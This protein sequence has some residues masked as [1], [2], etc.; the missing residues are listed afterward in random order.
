MLSRFS[1]L[2]SLLTQ[3]QNYWRI[4]PFQLSSKD[5]LPW[6]DSNN[7]LVEWLEKLSPEQVVAYK[8]DTKSLIHAISLFLPFISELEELIKLPEEKINELQLERGLDTG[9]PGRKL[10]QIVSMGTCSLQHHVGDEWL[11]WCS[12]KGYLGRILAAKSGEKVTSLE[13]QNELCISGQQEA[14]TRHLPM[15]FV[16]GD[17]FSPEVEL[18]FKP[19]QH[20]VALHAC[21][22]LHV[23][24]IRR[25]TEHHLK[26]I[27][28]SPC[29]YHLIRDDLYQP[30]SEPAKQSTLKFSKSELRIPL[31]ETVTG[32]ERV[33]KHRELEMSY[34]LG[35]DL[36][37]TLETGSKEYVSIPSVK[38]SELANGFEYFCRW[39]AEKKGLCLPEVDL[40]F[41]CQKGIERFWKMEKISLVQQ[42]FRRPLEIWLA[43]DRALYLEEKGYK[44]SVSTFC[45]KSVT[46][47]NIL[48]HGGRI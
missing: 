26:G 35:L 23:Q 8:A 32:G 4:E 20:A 29:C 21:G 47:R 38:K 2:D 46:P 22:D 28:I 19:N 40:E 43:L 44:V 12:G 45:E 18:L 33:K 42:V 41:W 27:T 6:N 15:E 5:T 34:R 13:W 10:T 24:L 30:L 14:D 3:C 17:A 48:I 16:Q 9:I 37:L 25:A 31:Q 7:E 39:A 36:L 11:E 1:Q